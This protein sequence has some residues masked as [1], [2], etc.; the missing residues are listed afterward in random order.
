[1]AISVLGYIYFRPSFKVVLTQDLFSTCF[2]AKK[3]TEIP[4]LFEVEL[5]NTFLFGSFFLLIFLPAAP[6]PVCRACQ[7]VSI[8][9]NM[10]DADDRGTTKGFRVSKSLGPRFAQILI[11]CQIL[12]TL[13]QAGPLVNVSHDR[14]LKITSF[15]YL[16]RINKYVRASCMQNFKAIQLP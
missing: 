3:R 6:F 14:E 4:I 5:S 9:I 10:R 1:M 7:L 8:F 12:L 15:R 13:V 16:A 2:L 11:F